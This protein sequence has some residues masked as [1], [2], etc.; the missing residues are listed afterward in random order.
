M[1]VSAADQAIGYI[2]M[3]DN[4]P[5]SLLQEGRDLLVG[6]VCSVIRK[7]DLYELT[8]DLYEKH[9]IGENVEGK[10]EITSE[11]VFPKVI[12]R[13]AI[14]EGDFGKTCVYYIKRQK[15]AWG[16]ENI[17]E[18]KAVTCFPNRNSVFRGTFIRSRRTDG[19]KHIRTDKWRT[20][21]INRKRLKEK[22]TA[23]LPG[24]SG[25]RL[26]HYVLCMCR[27]I[28]ALKHIVIRIMRH[29]TFRIVAQYIP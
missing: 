14:H 8:V 20:G 13:Q 7:D 17:L 26:F 1:E 10:I 12:T 6:K 11:D 9:S 27:F 2:S 21:E 29:D 19:R 4:V 3:Y 15:G 22:N 16:Y 5:E 18:E 23:S 28:Q 25:V 24:L